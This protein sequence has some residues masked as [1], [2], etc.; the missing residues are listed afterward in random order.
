[1]DEKGYASVDEMRGIATDASMAYADMPREKAK[2]NP[3]V[4]NH[5]KRCLSACFYQAMQDGENAT[6]VKEENC[7]GC[8]GCYSVCPVSGAVEIMIHQ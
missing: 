4:C 1:M 3:E 6:W 5:C 7:I 8:G 2:V